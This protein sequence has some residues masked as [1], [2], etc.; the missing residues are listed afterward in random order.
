MLTPEH[1]E[2]PRAEQRDE[3]TRDHTKMT[4]LLPVNRVLRDGDMIDR[5]IAAVF[6]RLAYTSVELRVL[7]EPEE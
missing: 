4:I 5:V 6:D 2:T 1:A 3:A 7:G